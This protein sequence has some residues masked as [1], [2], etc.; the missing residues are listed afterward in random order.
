[1]KGFTIHG[2]RDSL[3]THVICESG[4]QIISRVKM[5]RQTAT[6]DYV[7]KWDQTLFWG[8]EVTGTNSWVNCLCS[9]QSYAIGSKLPNCDKFVLSE[10]VFKPR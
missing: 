1:M 4:V 7:K 3:I 10:A 6:D 8:Y 5:Q 9:I 2:N